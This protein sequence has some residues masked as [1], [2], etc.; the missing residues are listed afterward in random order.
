[1]EDFFAALAPALT[2]PKA[3]ARFL[4][5]P[6]TTLAAGGL[7]VPDWMSVA[8]TEGSAPALTIT[9]PPLL[10]PDAELTEESLEQIVGGLRTCQGDLCDESWRTR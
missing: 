3:R 5:D 8:A 2:D 10:D 4:A 9:L 7:T 1:M 6:R